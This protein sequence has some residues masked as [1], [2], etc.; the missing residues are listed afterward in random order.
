MILNQPFLNCLTF[1][2]RKF[3]LKMLFLGFRNSYA[4]THQ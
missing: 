2:S 1:F 3:V 4:N